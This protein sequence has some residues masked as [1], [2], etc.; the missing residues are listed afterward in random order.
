MIIA[1]Q[2]FFHF[3]HDRTSILKYITIIIILYRSNRN[4]IYY[5][6]RLVQ[7]TSCCRLISYNYCL[8]IRVTHK[9]THNILYIMK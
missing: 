9:Y 2:F 4:F 5:T 8:S 6:I 3:H 7:Y 1:Q